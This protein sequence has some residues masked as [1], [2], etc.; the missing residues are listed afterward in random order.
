MN[1]GISSE[2]IALN[3]DFSEGSFFEQENTDYAKGKPDN[4]SYPLSQTSFHC[5]KTLSA[6][7]VTNLQGALF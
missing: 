5:L 7:T 2:F 1:Y 6:I 3:A 4:Q